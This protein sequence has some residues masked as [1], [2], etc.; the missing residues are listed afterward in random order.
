[1]GI[2]GFVYEDIDEVAVLIDRAPQLPT[3][4]L[5]VDEHLV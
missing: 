1:M 2:L 4:A 5:D 3:F